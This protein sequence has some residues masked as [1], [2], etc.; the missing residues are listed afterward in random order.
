[1]SPCGGV[2]DRPHNNRTTHDCVT[3]LHMS[4]IALPDR[5]L[6]LLLCI[7]FASGPPVMFYLSIRIYGHNSSRGCVINDPS[8][9]IERKKD[10][11]PV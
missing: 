4:L 5:Y 2:R 10:A 11:L 3:S 8:E 7:L 1:V 9:T 6:F